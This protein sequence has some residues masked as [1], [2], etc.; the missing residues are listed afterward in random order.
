MHHAARPL[1][2][3]L[4]NR[5]HC[6]CTE[7]SRDIL[8]AAEEEGIKSD[9]PGFP[10]VDGWLRCRPEESLFETWRDYLTAIRR[11]LSAE[12]FNK[13]H[14]TTVTRAWQV[15]EAA[16]G[17]FGFLRVSRAEELAIQDLNLAFV[18]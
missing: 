13:L 10:V 7:F 2:S 15:A 16:G 18:G 3:L 1:C 17:L 8:Q 11:L 9:S 4:I 6:L 5:R 14:L 12:S